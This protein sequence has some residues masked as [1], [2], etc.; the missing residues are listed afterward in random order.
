MN[1][2]D[3]PEIRRLDADDIQALL[4]RNHVGRLAFVRDGEADIRPLHYVFSV[5][6]IYGRT[7][8]DAHFTGIAETAPRVAFEVDEVES[9]HRWRSVIARGQFH[10]LSAT[11]D[12][13]EW[14]HA[15]RLLRRVVRGALGPG[16][17]VPGRNAIFRIRID[18]A[19]GLVSR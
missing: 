14:E 11:D 9:V 5:G 19:T 17:P 7:A 8:S 1:A 3:A 2:S 6:M 10:L 18:N 12:A 13:E 16:D 4:A 15:A